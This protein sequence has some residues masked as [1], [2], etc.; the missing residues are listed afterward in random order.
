MK[1]RQIHRFIKCLLHYVNFSRYKVT[2]LTVYI[3]NLFYLLYEE[4][5]KI[6]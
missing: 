2:L 3:L 6:I 4:K 5:N 1:V